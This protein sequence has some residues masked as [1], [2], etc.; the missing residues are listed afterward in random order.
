MFSPS[1]KSESLRGGCLIKFLKLAEDAAFSVDRIIFFDLLHNCLYAKSMKT[2][3]TSLIVLG[4][5]S[6]A[7]LAKEDSHP[8][9]ISVSGDCLRTVSQDRG[10]ITVTSENRDK[11]PSVAAQKTTDQYAKLLAAVKKIN[12]KD[13]ETETSE[14]TVNEVLD[15]TNGKRVSQ[16][17]S[18]RM[19][20]HIETSEIQRLGEVIQAAAKMGI[21][22][23]AG[24]NTFVSREKMKLE[25]EACL[26]EALKNSQMKAQKMAKAVGAKVGLV[27]SISEEGATTPGPIF[28]AE[29]GMRA[30]N[31]TMMSS[32]A[33]PSVVAGNSK[34]NL[35]VSVSYLLE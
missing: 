9:L 26:E 4:L 5:L 3:L 35:S 7:A 29:G 10:A 13:A 6:N 1:E 12:L 23:V 15:W 30:M 25:R 20:L 14:Y 34:I 2:K 24:L 27:Y 8:R 28:A 17:Y 33:P 32:E 18:A 16:G 11:D 22:E 31:K 21:K 19:G